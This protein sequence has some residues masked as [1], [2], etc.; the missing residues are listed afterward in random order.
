ME[1]ILF[2]DLDGV[3]N[4][5][6]FR[7]MF[8]ELMNPFL[9]ENLGEVVRKTDCKIV[10]SSDWRH[11]SL[12]T[13]TDTMQC[14]AFADRPGAGTVDL[15]ASSII[16]IT[17]DLDCGRVGEILAWVKFSDVEIKNWVAVDDIELDLPDCNFV[18]TDST[19]GMDSKVVEEI[20][21]KMNH[22]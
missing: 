5:D 2:L 22:G 14:L 16:G 1:R 19:I 13:I 4:T 12:K 10:I 17:P 20:V 6:D 7:D 18:K 15:I 3:L 8:G 21:R 9:V 11:G